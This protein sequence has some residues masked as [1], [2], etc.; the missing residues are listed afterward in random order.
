MHLSLNIY[1]VYVYRVSFINII[2]PMSVNQI[3]KWVVHLEA[4]DRQILLEKIQELISE[5]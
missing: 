5:T 3:L 4:S 2:K 1:I